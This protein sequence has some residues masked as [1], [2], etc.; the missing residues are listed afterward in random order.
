MRTRSWRNPTVSAAASGLALLLILPLWSCGGEEAA[1]RKV[2]APLR[3]RFNTEMMAILHDIRLAEETARAVDGNYVGW[4]ELRRSYLSR[5]IPSAY[6]IEMQDL[7]A[8]S[9]RVEIQ[10]TPS[11]LS[12]RLQVADAGAPGSPSCE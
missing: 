7:T 11:G 10:H 8:T 5:N 1:E 4:E 2:P 12:C 3:T 6:E 9:Y